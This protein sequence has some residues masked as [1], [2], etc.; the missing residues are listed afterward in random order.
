M[1]N[2][3]WTGAE[4][5]TLVRMWKA[6]KTLSEIGLEL[7]RSVRAIDNHRRVLQLPRRKGPPEYGPEL[8]I[9]HPRPQTRS[10]C[11][12]CSSCQAY[13]D[14]KADEL[15]CDHDPETYHFHT[16]PCVFAG[17]RHHNAV[18]W[19]DGGRLVV[20]DCPRSCS[21]DVAETGE[22]TACSVGECMGLA[23]GSGVWLVAE[24]T[25]NA[26]EKGWGDARLLL[27]R[28]REG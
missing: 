1:V 6:G 21:L 17:C 8:P 3:L 13:R 15:T 22:R 4:K 23:P 9:D 10:E 12:V 20:R 26:R 28:K 19:N 14:G 7:D 27:G 5:Q 2:R 11:E 16:R 25:R 18:D 24:A